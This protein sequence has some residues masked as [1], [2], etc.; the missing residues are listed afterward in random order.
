MR[1]EL[2][3]NSRKGRYFV[4]KVGRY[5]RYESVEIKSCDS[6]ELGK[7]LLKPGFHLGTTLLET[8]NRLIF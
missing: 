2:N 1:I 4:R 6:C 8:S 3:S 7:Y 5:L